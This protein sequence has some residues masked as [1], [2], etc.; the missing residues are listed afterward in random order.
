[1]PA[2]DDTPNSAEL[3]PLVVHKQ[4]LHHAHAEF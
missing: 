1:M 2:I 4:A 3:C